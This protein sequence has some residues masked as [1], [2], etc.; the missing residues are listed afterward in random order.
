MHK[1]FIIKKMDGLSHNYTLYY[2]I[3]Q[4]YLAS[5]EKDIL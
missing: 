5:P 1:G 2:E 3:D 4:I